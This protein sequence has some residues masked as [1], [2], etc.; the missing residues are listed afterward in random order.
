MRTFFL[1]RTF[2]L[3]R[4]FVICF[5][6]AVV[7]VPGSEFLDGVV[8]YVVVVADN[9]FEYLDVVVID[10]DSNSLDMAAA[11]SEMYFQ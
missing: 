11:G 5:D 7:A 1:L 3:W 6:G 10:S 4:F 9:G 8:V 2:F